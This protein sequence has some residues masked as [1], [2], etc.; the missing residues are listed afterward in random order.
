MRDI[1]LEDLSDVVHDGLCVQVFVDVLRRCLVLVFAQQNSL[2]DNQSLSPHLPP[3]ILDQILQGIEFF[4]DDFV[5]SY[6]NIAEQSGKNLGAVDPNT[7][8][9]VV[10]SHEA[11]V[12]ELAP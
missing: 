9:G 7:R 4:V 6:H 11:V 2:E 3:R 10:E 12:E 1:H 8:R 5:V